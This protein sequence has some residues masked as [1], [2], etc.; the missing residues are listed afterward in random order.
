MQ[1]R[2]KDSE[3][4]R[5]CREYASMFSL[6]SVIELGWMT[7]LRQLSAM[8][9][10]FGGGLHESCAAGASGGPLCTCQLRFETWNTT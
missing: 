7:G 1:S 10:S 9:W 6:R 3:G 5:S 4:V 8:A 2:D